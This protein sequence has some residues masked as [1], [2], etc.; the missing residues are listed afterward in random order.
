MNSGIWWIFISHKG[1]RTAKKIGRN[2]KRAFEIAQTIEAQFSLGDLG[3]IDKKKNESTFGEY[4]KSYLEIS[5]PASCKISTQKNY[6]YILEKN[7]LP[8]FGNTKITDINRY[9]IKQFLLKQFNS[10]YSASTVNHIKCAISNVLNLAVDDEIINANPAHR[11]GNFLKKEELNINKKITPL[12]REELSDLMKVF[13]EKFPNDYPL[14]LTL[15]RTGMRFGEA[16]GLQ[17]GD[18]DFENRSIH[19]QRSYIKG[20]IDTPKSGKTRKV[21][22]SIQLTETL[23]ELKNKCGSNSEWIF[24]NKNKN[25]I[26]GENWRR[27]IFY[28]VIK[29]ARIKKIRIHDLR[30]TYASL[31]L[32]LGTP[33]IYVRDQLG[34]SSIRITVDTYGHL[35]PGGNKEVVDK[36][37]D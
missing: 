14:A 23:K 35:V 21:D 17:W 34:H 12:T 27:R 37:D 29:L 11:L 2:K 24:I 1:K 16:L 25:P 36:L 33:M 9:K 20:R 10:G 3:I 22:M 15:A 19:I 32:Q 31:L 18:I 13:K 6:K 8:E 30:H 7:V 4:A 5:L 28:P 26:N